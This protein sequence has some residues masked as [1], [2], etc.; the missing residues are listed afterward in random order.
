LLENSFRSNIRCTKIEA[1][2][3]DLGAEA[4]TTNLRD[5]GAD[6]FAGNLGAYAFIIDLGAEA[7][8]TNLR[9]LGADAFARKFV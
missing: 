9:D 6:V 7:P 1:F 2:I 5:L 4:P 3:I 8:T